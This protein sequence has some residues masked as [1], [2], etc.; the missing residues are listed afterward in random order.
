MLLHQLEE[1]YMG[2]GLFFLS[3]I[4]MIPFDD[5]EEGEKENI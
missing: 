5:G 1:Q 2:L 4:E 3:P